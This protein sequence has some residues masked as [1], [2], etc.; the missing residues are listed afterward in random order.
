MTLTTDS[1]SDV[2]IEDNE[3][4][5]DDAEDGSDEVFECQDPS[6]GRG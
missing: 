4:D 3:Y 5:T 6:E 1:P 2:D